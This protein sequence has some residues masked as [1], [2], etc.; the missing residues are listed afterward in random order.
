MPPNI[1]TIKA[2]ESLLLISNGKKVKGH[3]MKGMKGK[4]HMEGRDDSDLHKI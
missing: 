4:G 3:E 2:H 1:L